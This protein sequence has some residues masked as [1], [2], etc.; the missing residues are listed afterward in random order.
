MRLAVLTS[1]PV[2]YQ[3]PLFRALA[4]EV[5]LTV[6]FGYEATPSD[7]A[8]AGFGVA[9]TW[10]VDLLAGYRNAFLCNEASR[11]QP[12]GFFRS[13]TPDIGARVIEG[14]YDAL[15][16]TGWHLKSYWQGIFAARRLGIPVLVRGDSHLDTPRSMMKKF[17][18]GMLYPTMLRA[19]DAALYVGQR[20]RAYYEHYGFPRSRLFFAPH[21]VDNEW[22]AAR[23]MPDAGAA[24]RARLGIPT[25]SA[26]LLFAG[27]LVPFKRPLD[28]IAAAAK[29][30]A[31]G[32]RVELMVAGAGP[33]AEQMAIHAREVGVVLHM[34]GFCNQTEMPAA[35]AAANVLVLPSDGRETW[36]LVANEALACNCP[37]V[38]S[39]AVGCAPDLVVDDRTGKVFHLGQVTELAHAIA[40]LLDHAPSAQEI[41]AKSAAYSLDAAANG[42][43]TAVRFVT[44][45]NG[46]P[47]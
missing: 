41:R 2:Q 32:R 28:L 11:L 21:C 9:F 1:H 18:K 19:F 35:Y 37:I 25:A 45:Q 39:D 33:L 34:L 40:M 10:D 5:D 36:G 6:Y 43:L 7:Q 47:T 20:S 27:K 15:L 24:L 42:I 22:F 14:R 26:V 8:A 16:V 30:E 12:N 38:V 44:G 46:M 13:D 3:A 4:Q 29:L 17:A 23:S 31:E